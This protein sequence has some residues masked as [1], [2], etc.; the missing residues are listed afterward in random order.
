MGSAVDSALVGL[1]IRYP[2]L[3]ALT[4]ANGPGGRSVVA[5]SGRPSGLSE[6]EEIAERP[7]EDAAE[8]QNDGQAPVRLVAEQ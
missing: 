5:P 1:W 2:Q 6:A 7:H 8:Q 3:H 4:C